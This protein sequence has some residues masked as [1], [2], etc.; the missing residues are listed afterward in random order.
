MDN[1][2]ARQWLDEVWARVLS[3]GACEPDSEV[4]R[5]V[6]S[7]LV[8]IRYAVM[9]QM[10]G[11]IANKSRSLLCLQLGTGKVPG[12]W[13]AR[14]FCAAVIVPWVADNQHVLGRSADPYVNHPLRRPRLDEGTNGVRDTAEWDA[15][16]AFLC[17][18]DSAPQKELEAAF[19][20]CL[21]SAA[22]QMLAQSF[23]YEVPIR[24]SLPQMLR[25]LEMFLSEPSGGL[26]PLAT[27]A[28][29][30][31]VLGDAFSLFSK[32]SSQGL[33][34][35]DSSTGAPADVTC[36]DD[37]GKV[38]LAIEVKDRALTL[39]D[40]RDT[41]SKIQTSAD[42]LSN[43]LFA[44]PSVSETERSEIGE[45]MDGAWAS[46]LNIN[47]ID[48]L[49]LARATF[50]LLSEDWRPKLLRE[51]GSELDRRADHLHRRGWSDLLSAI[52][53]VDGSPTASSPANS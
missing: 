30:M 35:A 40:I 29:L 44:V 47:Q 3:D 45:I 53:E 43:L 11:K 46:G 10:L 14:S 28:A 41:R 6:N 37:K 15:L 42:P 49:D 34:Q 19:L 16:V 32:V 52:G 13:D 25:A 9:T 33:N 18:L 36:L 38:V 17:P 7:K 27:T 26:R 1:A 22:R 20:R 48:I 39:A 12:G 31:A 2:E 23:A 8:S 5:L 4:D 50:T 21:N 24:I 51:I